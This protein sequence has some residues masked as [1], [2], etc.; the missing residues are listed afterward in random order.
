MRIVPK[1]EAAEEHSENNKAEFD[2]PGYNRVVLMLIHE[3]GSHVSVSQ[4]IAGHLKDIRFKNSR[5]TPFVA[6]LH[7]VRNPDPKGDDLFL[8]LTGKTA[9]YFV[10]CSKGVRYPS[11]RTF[12]DYS[13][14]LYVQYSFDYQYLTQ[15]DAVQKAVLSFVASFETDNSK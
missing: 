10:T 12:A 8:H 2:K 3:R 4:A 11:C 1:R 14:D 13:S 5:Q 7:V 9:D 6:G 15:W